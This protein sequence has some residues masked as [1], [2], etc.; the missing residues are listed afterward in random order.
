MK[1]QILEEAGQEAEDMI[2]ET[3]TEIAQQYAQTAEY[4]AKV[5]AKNDLDILS[6]RLRQ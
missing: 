2:N 6:E 1:E 3:A 4:N 5:A